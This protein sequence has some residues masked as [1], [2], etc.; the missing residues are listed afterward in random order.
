MAAITG[1]S[2]RSS[3]RQTRWANSSSWY[4]AGSSAPIGRGEA[5]SSREP[6]TLTGPDSPAGCV[7]RSRRARLGPVLC[8]R[9]PRLEAIDRV[10]GK[11]PGLIDILHPR[12]LLEDC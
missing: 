12:N 5:T 1:D 11:Q 9:R 7:E 3:P 10:G 2:T 6:R 4:I 8:A